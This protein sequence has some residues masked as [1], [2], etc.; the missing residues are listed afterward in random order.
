MMDGTM[1]TRTLA[2]IVLPEGETIFHE[3]ATRIEIDDEA[4][5]E[6]L[7]L[8]Q[9]EGGKIRIDPS[10]WPKLRAAIN[11]MIRQCRM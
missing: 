4:T 1:E 9:C 2:V 10:E 7:T 3:R 6:F 5:G 11:R 8:H